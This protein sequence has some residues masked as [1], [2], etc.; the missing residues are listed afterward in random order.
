MC[1]NSPP[2]ALLRKMCS[3]E[4]QLLMCKH[5]S[6][7][8]WHDSDCCTQSSDYS[9]P[10]PSSVL[11]TNT[12]SSQSLRSSETASVSPHQMACSFASWTT[13]PCSEIT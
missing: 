2:R 6:K 9:R 1:L 12:Y 7:M 10:S 5:P 11:Q 13:V 8:I 4:P 3:G